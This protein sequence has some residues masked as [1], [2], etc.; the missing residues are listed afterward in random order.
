MEFPLRTQLFLFAF[1]SSLTAQQ[2]TPVP[3]T[4]GLLQPIHT[5]ADQPDYGL[6]AGGENYKVGFEG[7][8]EFVPYAGADYS[9]NQ[10]LRWRTTS[11]R[12]GTEEL[13]T[14]APHGREVNGVR[15]EYELGG[16]VEAY[17]VSSGG[18]EQTFVIADTPTVRAELVVTGA[19]TTPLRAAAQAATHSAV[20][21]SDA[22]GRPLVEYGAATAIDANGVKF[23]M[24]TE[25]DGEHVRLVLPE[26]DV[27][28]AAFPLVVDPFV[29]SSSASENVG[30]V[31]QSHRRSSSQR[32][33][34]FTRIASATDHDVL[35]CSV[36]GPAWTSINVVHSNLSNRTH[37]E[38]VACI[39]ALG[40]TFA[41]YTRDY[42][43]TKDLAVYQTGN[44]MIV[45]TP[46]PGETFIRPCLASG[47]SVAVLVYEAE[48]AGTSQVR[49]GLLDAN[50]GTFV[51]YG[52]V[53]GFGNG[54]AYPSISRQAD[55]AEWMICWADTDATTSEIKCRTVDYTG[56]LGVT[57][58]LASST[59][60]IFRDVFVAGSAPDWAA[61]YY[62]TPRG[63]G[64]NSI[65]CV[66]FDT[67]GLP[68]NVLH[69][70]SLA[71]GR[72]YANGGIAFDFRTA[73][74]WMAAYTVFNG[75]SSHNE[76]ARVSSPQNARVTEIP[77]TQDN[78]F[79]PAVAFDHSASGA[80]GLQGAFSGIYAT[81]GALNRVMG[82]ELPY[83]AE[84]Y[85]PLVV[86]ASTD[87]GNT[88]ED[89]VFRQPSVAGNRNFELV[90][91]EITPLAALMI[92]QVQLSV[93]LDLIGMVGCT[94]NVDP[95]VTLPASDMPNLAYKSV[96]WALPGHAG[97]LGVDPLVQWFWVDPAA[98]ALGL[99]S[100]SAMQIQIR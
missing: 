89:D 32:I 10:F 79:S 30:M 56:A 73:S 16:V 99:V 40:S 63:I 88:I 29:L 21:F 7:G 47:V 81:Q 65:R 24:L 57:A 48:I 38:H 78:P 33:F 18:V 49:G 39:R 9:E 46:P 97:I 55:G 27:R 85:A 17:D 14:R 26:A 96:N 60:R 98:N 70:W 20:E 77:Q 58:T 87:C 22:E 93:P 41:A 50:A 37:T 43:L 72:T 8:F 15:Y 76:Y 13:V 71:G 90:L 54:E 66:R 64:T 34:A 59:S 4:A 42:A 1:T 75:L 31:A 61:T 74:I 82:V 95:L 51:P 23:P 91:A 35:V 94:L 67:L 2:P 92:G 68:V 80:A 19:V 44:P 3:L 45:L 84:V 100:S 62:S 28:L 83:P 69:D 11:V 5:H 12:V 36:S 53:I 6:W 86:A 52:Q 25:W